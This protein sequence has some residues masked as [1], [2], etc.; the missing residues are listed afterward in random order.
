MKNS[1]TSNRSTFTGNLWLLLPLVCVVF[2]VSCKDGVVSSVDDEIVDTNFIVNFPFEMT[3]DIY[4]ELSVI[5]I[6]NNN[7]KRSFS[8]TEF[9]DSSLHI[10]VYPDTLYQLFVHRIGYNV[11]L[12]DISL[13][14]TNSNEIDMQFIESEV[15]SIQVENT[16]GDEITGFVKYSLYYSDFKIFEGLTNEYGQG[17]LSIDAPN[18]FSLTIEYD[19]KNDSWVFQEYPSSGIVV[20]LQ[21]GP[22]SKVYLTPRKIT[23][24][25]NPATL[26]I[27]GT[28]TNTNNGSSGFIGKAPNHEFYSAFVRIDDYPAV[29]VAESP[30]YHS[31]SFYVTNE[32][33]SANILMISKDEVLEELFSVDVGDVWNFNHS[34]A[35]GDPSQA[36]TVRRGTTVANFVNI[37]KNEYI[38][39]YTLTAEVEGIT[40]T[41]IF[42]GTEPVNS[43][44]FGF[45]DTFKIIETLSGQWF[46]INSSVGQYFPQ[47]ASTNFSGRALTYY[48]IEND[49]SYY[50]FHGHMP[51]R[52][53]PVGTKKV[54]HRHTDINSSAFAIKGTGFERSSVSSGK[55]SWGVSRVRSE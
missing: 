51:F 32:S 16:T 1:I 11:F 2:L 48:T 30:D 22:L 53:V 8:L 15:G 18:D 24:S 5:L 12:E 7:I 17:S 23:E 9:S 13:Q 19:T 27:S 39:T 37:E 29:L 25:V 14:E 20:P 45:G 50:R 31:N 44:P 40:E 3:Q 35:S 28:I 49:E 47:V 46:V 38:T 41:Y 6:L 10:N 4:D 54:E 33:Q 55:T 21:L 34:Y 43:T 36:R 26:E 52:F 42:N